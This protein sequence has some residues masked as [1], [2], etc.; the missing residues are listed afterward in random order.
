[1][2]IASISE[3]FNAN[4]SDAYQDTPLSAP[5]PPLTIASTGDGLGGNGQMLGNDLATVGGGVNAGET[6]CFKCLSF[7][8]VIGATLGLLVLYRDRIVK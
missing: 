2:S 6:I 1:M 5:V 4:L 8:L 3:E 7:W